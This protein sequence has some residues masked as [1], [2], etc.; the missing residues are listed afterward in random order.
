MKYLGLALLIVVSGIVAVAIICALRGDVAT[1]KEIF[2]HIALGALI[3]L[4][5]LF[6]V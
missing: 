5:L 4:W 2:K 1:A 6:I 3:L